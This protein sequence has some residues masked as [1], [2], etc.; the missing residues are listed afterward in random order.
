M[1]LLPPSRG[2]SVLTMGEEEFIR[3]VSCGEIRLGELLSKYQTSSGGKS[4][5]GKSGGSACASSYRWSGGGGGGAPEPPSRRLEDPTNEQ[6]EADALGLQP[7]DA[8]EIVPFQ[9]DGGSLKQMFKSK[10][11]DMTWKQYKQ[12]MGI[13]KKT[14]QKQKGG[15]KG[16]NRQ[17][18]TNPKRQLPA[19]LSED[20]DA[21]KTPS[22]K[23][24]AWQG[25]RRGAPW[26]GRNDLQGKAVN[27]QPHAKYRR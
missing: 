2:A 5:A 8:G 21:D 26:S 7:N 3:R 18:D 13:P 11:A 19:H 16:G 4:G 14:K 12:E 22:S 23:G 6:W 15:K 20:N 10:P 9:L 25:V 24:R 17:A 27:L 1:E